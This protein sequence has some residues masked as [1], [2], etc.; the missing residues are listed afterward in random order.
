MVRF[1]KMRPR[2]E[3]SAVLTIF[4]SPIAFSIRSA[5]VAYIEGSLR[6]PSR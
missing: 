3:S 4:G 5:A 1:M 2:R 6:Q